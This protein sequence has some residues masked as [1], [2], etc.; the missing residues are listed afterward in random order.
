MTL[1]VNPEDLELVS[2]SVDGSRPSSAGSSTCAVQSD[3]AIG[4]GGAIARTDS[5]E[6]DATS[7]LSCGRA[8]EIVAAPR[9]DGAVG[10]RRRAPVMA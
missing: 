10:A 7:T 8:R 2:D 4:R 5:G 6:I 9:W 1:V 3:R